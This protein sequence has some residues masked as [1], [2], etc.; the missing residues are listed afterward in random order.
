MPINQHALCRQQFTVA[1]GPATG[2][3]P[4]ATELI[5]SLGPV[6]ALLSRRKKERPSSIGFASFFVH[7]RPLLSTAVHSH[8]AHCHPQPS[9]AMAL[10]WVALGLQCLLFLPFV[11]G[12]LRE[13]Y[14]LLC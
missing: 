4:A 11:R 10:P 12:L 2:V 3:G 8:V 6:Q 14:N 5:A 9:T 13:N 7:C 1:V